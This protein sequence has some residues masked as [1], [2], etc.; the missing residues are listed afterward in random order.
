MKR[1]LFLVLAV[2][3]QSLLFSQP[4]EHTFD[5]KFKGK[6]IGKLIA[7]REVKGNV[8]KQDL[9]TKTEVNL[10]AL[11]VHVESEV[12]LIKKD[13][14]LTHSVSYRHANRDSEDIVSEILKI[15]PEEYKV[16]RN[17]KE[18]NLENR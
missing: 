4:L 17:G 16:K 6:S 12:K 2:S 11:S 13:N 15:G 7:Q 18:F 1:I 10:I 3:L 5:V 14:L 9:R 8:I